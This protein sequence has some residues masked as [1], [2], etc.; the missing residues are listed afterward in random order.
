MDKIPEF[1]FK[2]FGLF[3]LSGSG[4]LGIIVAALLAL[5]VTGLFVF[6]VG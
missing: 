3:E 6:H 4:T 1:K 2:L 5:L